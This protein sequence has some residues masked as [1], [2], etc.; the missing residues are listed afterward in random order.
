MPAADMSE[1]VKPLSLTSL[2]MAASIFLTTA[3]GPVSASVVIEV[4][5]SSFRPASQRGE[6][7]S[8]Q[9]IL[10]FVPP[11]SIPMSKF[12]ILFRIAIREFI[13]PEPGGF[14]YFFEVGEFWFPTDLVLC[15]RGVGGQDWNVAR[16]ALRFDDLEVFS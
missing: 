8:K 1:E 7:A 15:L 14:D 5:F 9:P 12:V 16:S 13:M 4:F 6:C 3:C 11:T 2:S 10:I